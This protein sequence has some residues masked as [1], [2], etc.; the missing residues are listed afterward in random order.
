M[1]EKG[2]Q[3]RII[4]QQDGGNDSTIFD[5]GRVFLVKGRLDR[6]FEELLGV[7]REVSR[8]LDQVTAI[9]AP[10]EIQEGTEIHP[11]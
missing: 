6:A 9:C 5:L 7:G 11:R 4:I 8:T 2:R 3:G 1:G 10:T